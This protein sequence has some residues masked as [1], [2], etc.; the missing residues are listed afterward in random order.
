MTTLLP[1]ANF[2]ISEAL[3]AA[4]AAAVA[5]AGANLTGAV[6]SGDTVTVETQA[7]DCHDIA[8]DVRN[9]T[10]SWTPAMLNRD[11]VA[12]NVGRETRGRERFAATLEFYSNSAANGTDALLVKDRSGKRL[13][14]VERATNNVLVAVVE[15][16]AVTSSGIDT[17]GDTIY[18]ATLSNA[19]LTQPVWE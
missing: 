14:Y 3:T 4:Q 18:T 8:A 6:L 12:S 17:D 19:G 2:R 5:K 15:L 10:E 1:F 7:I 11:S 9:F 16:G 13:L